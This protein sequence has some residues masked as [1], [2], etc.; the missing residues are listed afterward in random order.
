VLPGDVALQAA[1][2]LLLAQALLGAVLN[3]KQNF[4]WMSIKFRTA[5]LK[6][7]AE[8]GSKG[9]MAMERDSRRSD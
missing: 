1:Q 8:V 6:R 2:D 7:R 9:L 4:P 5:A 3:V